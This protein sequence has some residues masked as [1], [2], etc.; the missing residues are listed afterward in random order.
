M[1]EQL[2]VYTKMSPSER[3]LLLFLLG[4]IIGSFSSVVYAR[5]KVRKSIVAPRSHCPSCNHTLH[6]RD[7]IPLFSYV[8]SGGRCRYCHSAIPVRYLLLEMIAGLSAGAVGAYF[9]WSGGILACLAWVLLTSIVAVI[10]RPHRTPDQSGFMLVEVLVSILL[11]TLVLGAVFKAISL[12]RQS[13]LAAQRRTQAL[14]LAR[15]RFTQAYL[16]ASAAVQA[17]QV[18]QDQSWTYG[19]FSVQTTYHQ[20]DVW[21]WWVTLKVSCQA[22][23]SSGATSGA[24]VT[25]TGVV[26]P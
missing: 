9:G 22:C 20:R 16:D 13:A 2:D 14:G 4:T 17:G 12:S 19:Q 7:L 5:V 25:L 10:Q 21:S 1:I 18:P 11:L 3:G 23:K 24:D 8:L 15:D 26:S 6:A